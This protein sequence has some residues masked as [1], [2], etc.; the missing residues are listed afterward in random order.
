V[1][2]ADNRA[3]LVNKIY[4]LNFKEFYVRA[5]V[6]YLK[7]L[8]EIVGYFGHPE[9]NEFFYLEQQSM[10]TI[11]YSINDNSNVRRFVCA[12]CRSC[13]DSAHL[14]VRTFEVEVT[15]YICCH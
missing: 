5:H 3:K 2:A 12:V 6:S 1:K 14:Q 11:M 8:K 7:E 15:A 4:V 9:F 13:I 10:V